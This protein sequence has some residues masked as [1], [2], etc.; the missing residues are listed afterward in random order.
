[1]KLTVV[2]ATFNSIAT[3]EQCLKSVS[4]IRTT[5]ECTI[6]Q[7]VIDGGSKDGTV[8]WIRANHPEVRI[9]AQT[10]RGLYQALN[11]GVNRANGDYIM[12]LHSDDEIGKVDLREIDFQT[13]V[14][15]YGTVEFIDDSSKLLFRRRAP[16][17]PKKCLSQYP[18]VFHPNAIYPRWLLLKYPFDSESHGNAADMWQINAFRDEVKFVPTKA[19]TYRFRIHK[20]STTVKSL[21]RKFP[22]IYWVWRVYLFLFF[23]DHR[24][25]R[26]LN[27]L[28]G[29]RTWS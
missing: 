17:F 14:V 19:I 3:L 7:L 27:L 21:G 22:M 2:I 20:Q 6:E 10:G 13:N 25:S 1:M 23:E 18:F 29:K 5:G 4:L 26:V 12:F 8:E 24:L 15:V 11:E 28:R 16:L 9:E